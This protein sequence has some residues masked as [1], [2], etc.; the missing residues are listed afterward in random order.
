MNLDTYR[1]TLVSDVFVTLPS[2][3]GKAII[4]LLDELSVLELRPVRRGY[5]MPED[6]QHEPFARFV[7][8]QI[9]LKGYATH[10]SEGPFSAKD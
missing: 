7:L 3:S 4:G 6:E 5:E 10:G 1:S 2:V 9:V 8:T